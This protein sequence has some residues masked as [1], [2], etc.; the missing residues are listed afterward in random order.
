MGNINIPDFEE[1]LTK[2]LEINYPNKVK[3]CQFIQN[4]NKL[5]REVFSKSIH[6]NND[7]DLANELAMDTLLKDYKFSKFYCILNILLDEY[8]SLFSKDM[9]KEF[10]I[11]FMPICEQI[12]M[13]Y[14]L[15]DAILKSKELITLRE[16]LKT[17]IYQAMNEYLTFKV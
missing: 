4:R 12:F 5:A 3:D 14:T 6:R 10:A 1:Y 17:C 13:R 16:E 15:N 11:R 9:L 8:E 7:Y 2:Y